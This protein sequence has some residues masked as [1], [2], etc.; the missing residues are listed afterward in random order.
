MGLGLVGKLTVMFGADF[1][2]FDKAMKTQQKKLAKWSRDTNRLGNT[3]TRNLTLPILALGAGAVKLASDFEESLNKVRVSFGD[4]SKEV[5]K[6]AKTTL[7]SFGIAEGSA[8]EMAAL[9]GDMGTA[10]GFTE[11]SA[12]KMSNELVG[13]AGD[14]A[15]FKNISIDIAQTAL[16]GIF[17]GETESL[18]KLGIMTTEATLKNSEYF[19]SLN[20]SWTSLTNLE[21][22]QV[23][24]MEV[25]RQSGKATGDFLRTQ[26][27][28]ANQMRILQETIK[29]TGAEFGKSLIPLATDLVKVFTKGA[30]AINN[31]TQ[32]N[33]EWVIQIGLIGAL[34]GPVLKALAAFLS[35]IEK[36]T[37][38]IPKLTKAIL[39]PIGIIAALSFLWIKLDE[40]DGWVD[41][42]RK[43]FQR[44]RGAI[45]GVTE[46]TK[47]MSNVFTKNLDFSKQ[48]G[49]D[50]TDPDYLSF[51]MGRINP[52][53]PDVGAKS[54]GLFGNILSQPSKG[55]G[56]NSTSTR[57]AGITKSMERLGP[58]LL[59]TGRA[60]RTYYENI[61]ESSTMAAEAQERLTKI[62][63]LFEDIMTSAMTSALDSQEGFFKSF[64]ENLKKAI[65]QLLVQLAVIM[66]IKLL[67]GD[68]STVKEAL[69][70]ASTKV[71]GFAEGGLVTGPTVGLIGEGA[72]TNASNPEVIAPLDKLKSMI[73]GGTQQVEV[74]GSISGNDIFLSNQRGQIGRFRSV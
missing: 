73:G 42:L 36:L 20:K 55:T 52:Q 63:A 41:N 1:K 17:T 34:F 65:K 62:T 56:E 60:W 35:V 27:G 5:E 3:L 32:E 51:I 14:L 31:M 57:I 29:E 70:L 54:G 58:V 2:G 74:F 28:F 38:W 13:L 30:N 66:A 67:L 16:A 61:E 50:P 72:G 64:I 10:L 68:A 19:K 48:K 26:D 22:I 45:F 6:F 49:M 39:G 12:A 47:K 43:K 53:A 9:F 44:L 18:K 46:E 7:K 71:L 21:K 24:Y 25:L 40:G 4:S 11:D 69:K 8:L 15:S 59:E 37:L 33:R 23:R